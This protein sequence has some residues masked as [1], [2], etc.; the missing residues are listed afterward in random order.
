MGG[1]VGLF[2]ILITWASLRFEK[3]LN[4]SINPWQLSIFHLSIS[5]RSEALLIIPT[6][7]FMLLID[8]CMG[9]KYYGEVLVRG[10][11]VLVWGVSV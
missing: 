5:N 6:W 11:V 9:V 8:V 10:D 3:R 2:S 7:V 1:G 4:F